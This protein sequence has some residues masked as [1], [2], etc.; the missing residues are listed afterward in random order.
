MNTPDRFNLF[1]TEVEYVPFTV[2]GGKHRV[3]GTVI[4][5]VQ[6]AEIFDRFSAGTSSGP[7]I[8]CRI[9]AKKCPSQGNGRIEERKTGLRLFSGRCR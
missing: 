5:T 4:D 7:S 8:F 1:A 3:G 6:R 9:N 2:A